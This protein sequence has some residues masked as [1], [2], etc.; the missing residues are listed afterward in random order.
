MTNDP[1]VDYCCLLPLDK[2][3]SSLPK[4]AI[5]NNNSGLGLI[6]VTFCHNRFRYIYANIAKPISKVII[7]H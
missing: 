1:E 2:L 3:L 5:V 6:G 7:W 4:I